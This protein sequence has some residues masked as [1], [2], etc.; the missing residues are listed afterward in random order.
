MTA[1][2]VTDGFHTMSGGLA[3][4]G[5]DELR[6]AGDALLDRLLRRGIREAHV[7]ALAG[8]ARAEMDVGEHRHPGLE[9]QTLPELLRIR[10]AD[11]PAR[12][13][14]VRPDVE[15]AV[16]HLAFHARYF[17]EQFCYQI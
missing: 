5:A 13:G 8:H 12:L 3:G 11:A 14:D 1:A 17:I 6:H 7:L 15:G 16:G 4:I 9:Q 2:T 10:G